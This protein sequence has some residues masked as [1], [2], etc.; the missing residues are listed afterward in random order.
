MTFSQSRPFRLG[1]YL[2]STFAMLAAFGASPV[3][4]QS[5]SQS[6]LA[7]LVSDQQGAAIVGAEVRAVDASTGG[8]LTTV[9]NEAGRYFLVN[10]AP[11]LYTVTFSKQGFTTYKI[12]AQKVDVGTA[13][14]INATLE[15]G[16]TATTVEVTATAG[17]ELQTTNAAV[18]NT[19]TS[20]ALMMPAQPGPRR[21]HPRR[22]P[23]G[24]YAQ[25]QTRARSPIRTY[26]C[27]MAAT[28]PTTWL[29]TTPATSP[30]SPDRRHADQRQPL[31]RHSH[32]G[33]EHRRVQGLHVQPDRRFLRLHRRPDP[34][35]HQARHQS[36]SRLG[37]RLLLRHQRRRG[38]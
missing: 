19:I 15:V 21:L 23:A 27:S 14:T 11:G 17:A 6:S 35:G 38:Q 34:D 33:R 13:T 22:A 4:S 1:F 7:G 30:T 3:W 29:A 12:A 9:S 26:S 5:T 31:G 2:S 20:K 8:V 36:I 24:H 16:S 25:R 37:V 18:G 28:T 32:A 10:V